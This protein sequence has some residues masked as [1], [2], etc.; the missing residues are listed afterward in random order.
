MSTQAGLVTCPEHDR[1]LHDGRCD[2]CEFHIPE[3]DKE[4]AQRE[5]ERCRGALRAAK[6]AHKPP[7]SPARVVRVVRDRSEWSDGP[8]VTEGL[9]E[10]CQERR[11][12]LKV[13]RRTVCRSCYVE[14]T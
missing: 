5:L 10:G 1:V 4:L 2:R 8:G 13:A 11:P 7:E 9:C 3:T 6:P 12:V 14:A